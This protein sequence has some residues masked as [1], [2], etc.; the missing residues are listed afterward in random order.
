MAETGDDPDAIVEA[1]GLR[2][3]TDDNE[4]QAKAAEVIANNPEQ[5]AKYQGNPK[6]L[7]WFVGQIMSA[8]GGKANPQKVNEFLRKKL[9]G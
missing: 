3:I 5:V 9:D 2:Q 8:T 6:V 4:L 1:K 7:G